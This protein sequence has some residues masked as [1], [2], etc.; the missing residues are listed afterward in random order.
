MG[1]GK[2][3]NQKLFKIYEQSSLTNVSR[4]FED[5]SFF[6]SSESKLGACCQAKGNQFA[7]DHSAK[8]MDKTRADLHSRIIV[9][10]QSVDS[11]SK[12]IQRRRAPV[13]DLKR[14]SMVDWLHNGVFALKLPPSSV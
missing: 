5:R 10:I 7:K 8:A 9:T 6:F 13:T 12:R 4:S 3:K 2:I 1:F 14:L 11:I